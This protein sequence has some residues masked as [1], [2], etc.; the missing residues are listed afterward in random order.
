M[1]SIL[2][3]CKETR[4]KIR[5]IEGKLDQA[6]VAWKRLDDGSMKVVAS[7]T[8][9]IREV[10]ELMF[11]IKGNLKDIDA[12]LEKDSSVRLYY[13]QVYDRYVQFLETAKL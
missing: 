13:N 12:Q 8:D 7:Y 4:E 3:I 1:A 6:V 9:K 10:R 5:V 2:N 11:E